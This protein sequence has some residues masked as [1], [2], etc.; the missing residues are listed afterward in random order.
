MYAVLRIVSEQSGV[1]TQLVASRDDLLDFM[2][3]R[4][5]V[6]L[7]SGW[8]HELVGERLERLLAGELGLTVKG[9]RVE[10]L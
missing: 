6:A 3:G 8:R 5:G 10:L 1:A 9:G 2:L 4:P 7:S